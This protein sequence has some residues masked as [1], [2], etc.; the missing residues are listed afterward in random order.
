MLKGGNMRKKTFLNRRDF[1]RTSAFGM[2]SAGV[3][4]KS[5]WPQTKEAG[6]ED[7]QTEDKPEIKI[8]DYRILGRTGFKVSDLAVG[9]IQDEGLIAAMLDAGVNLSI[10]QKAILEPTGSSAR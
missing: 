7:K 3:A 10:R 2:L 5:G 8:K 9:Y 4:A 1:L 6:Q